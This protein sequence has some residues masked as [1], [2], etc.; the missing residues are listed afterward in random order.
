MLLH[1]RALRRNGRRNLS[2]DVLVAAHERFAALGAEPWAAQTTVELD[3][4]APGREQAELT[5]TEARV[6]RLVV[7]GL[8]NRE[9]A[10]ELFVSVATVEAH[11]TRMYRKLHVRSRTELARVLR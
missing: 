5:P 9:I 11:L 6:A 2:A 4:V 1:G 10:G 3:R 7:A 8:R